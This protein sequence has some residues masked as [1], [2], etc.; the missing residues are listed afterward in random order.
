MPRSDWQRWGGGGRRSLH[1][2]LALGPCVV[3]YTLPRCIYFYAN[4]SSLAF[5][6]TLWPLQALISQPG[7]VHAACLINMLKGSGHIFGNFHFVA[8]DL[9]KVS[10]IFFSLAFQIAALWHTRFNMPSGVTRLHRGCNVRLLEDL[11]LTAELSQ[12]FRFKS[13]WLISHCCKTRTFHQSPSYDTS[14][15]EIDVSFFSLLDTEIA[16]IYYNFEFSS[17]LFYYCD[18]FS[19]LDKRYKWTALISSTLCDFEHI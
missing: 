4:V 7:H 1:N 17:L 18:E 6:F 14:N 9:G 19:R 2:S 10:F 3:L 12:G 5:L 11:I 16:H 15:G 13:R 8:H